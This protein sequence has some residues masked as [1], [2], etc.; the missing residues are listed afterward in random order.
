MSGDDGVGKDVHG[1][2]SPFGGVY[3]LLVPLCPA[4]DSSVPAGGVCCRAGAGVS[5]CGV[6][7]TRRGGG[8]LV[9]P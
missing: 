5:G 7:H 1:L 8:G 3:W 4:D 2:L 6:A 9:L